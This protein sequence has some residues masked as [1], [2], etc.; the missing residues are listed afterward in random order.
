MLLLKTPGPYFFLP[1]LL[2]PSLALLLSPSLWMKAERRTCSPI[3]RPRTLRGAVGNADKCWSVNAFIA[4][5]RD[6]NGWSSFQDVRKYFQARFFSA[7]SP[8]VL[9]FSLLLSLPTN[10]FGFSLFSISLTIFLLTLLLL[11]NV[12]KRWHYSCHSQSTKT[13]EFVPL[14]CQVEESPFAGDVMRFLIEKI[15]SIG[16]SRSTHLE[17]AKI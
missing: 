2:P 4:L 12:R 13:P 15:P 8:S 10:R 11:K 5:T 9:A 17:Q 3:H 14:L 7:E 16:R 6:K 1:P